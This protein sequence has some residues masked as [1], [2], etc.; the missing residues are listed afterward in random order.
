MRAYSYKDAVELGLE[1]EKYLFAKEEM[2]VEAILHFKV[3]GKKRNVQC[4]FQ[5]IRTG[6]L[7]IL[8]AFSGS[9]QQYTPR[10]KGI[11]FSEPDI[12]NSLYRISTASNSKGRIVWESAILLFPPECREEIEARIAAVFEG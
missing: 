12:E 10:D 1:L 4:F 6:A 7:F 9:N 8:S 11:D 2:T 5:D 3:W